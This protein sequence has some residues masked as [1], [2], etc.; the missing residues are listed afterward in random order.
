MIPGNPIQWVNAINEPQRK[1]DPGP[2]N[3]APPSMPSPICVHLKV[4]QP[5]CAYSAWMVWNQRNKTQ[6]NLQVASFHQ[7]AEQEKE[8]LA[9]YR[10]NLLVPNVQVINNGSGETRWRCPQAELVKI[11]FDGAVFS[12]SNMFS[13]GVVIRDSNGAVLASCSQ[14]IP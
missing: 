11:N 7:V 5:T 12:A 2:L 3:S 1:M 8:M 4:S 13:I 9:Q 6:L 14:K 10:A